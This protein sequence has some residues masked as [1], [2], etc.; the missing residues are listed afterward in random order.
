[1]GNVGNR[2]IQ[3]LAALAL[4]SRVPGAHF[5]KVQLPEWGINIPP[6]PDGKARIAVVHAEQ[7]PHAAL[8]AALNDGHIDRVDIRSYAQRMENFLSAKAY[9][10]L[11]QVPGVIGAGADELLISVRQG[12]VLDGHHRDYVLVPI[13]FY[14]DLLDRTGLSPV[15]LGQI[16]DSHYM[17]AVRRRFPHA[18]YV[19]SRGATIDFAAIRASCN[20]V[21]SIST[22]SWLAAWLSQAHRIILP[23]LGL[24]HPLQAR[25]TNLLP[26]GDPRYQ[27]ELFPFHYAQPVANVEAAHATIEGSW[28]TMTGKALAA[29]LDNAHHE[30]RYDMRMAAFDEI[31][32]L[33]AYPDVADAVR[34]GNVSSGRQHYEACG[35][36]EGREPCRVERAWYCMTYPRAALELGQGVICDELEHWVEIGRERGYESP[37][38]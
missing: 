28:R 26:L 21:P 7:I 12:D 17:R 6:I 29:M 2:M 38:A 9:R 37:L 8:A 10:D 16:E 32:Y 3:Y 19:P 34:N 20:I 27:F 35:F 30:R 25:T 31:F 18:R 4:A 22:F 23:V 13:G 14:A 1:M 33:S 24:F 5:H 36:A 15:F 11:F